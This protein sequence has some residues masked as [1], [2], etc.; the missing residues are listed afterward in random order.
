MLLQ[1]LEP[2]RHVASLYHVAIVG[3]WTPQRA[4]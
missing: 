1:P 2:R 3:A 4:L